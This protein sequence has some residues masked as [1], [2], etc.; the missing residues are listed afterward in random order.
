MNEWRYLFMKQEKYD[1]IKNLICVIVM[2]LSVGAYLAV[3]VILNLWHPYWYIVVAGGLICGMVS[4]ILDTMS[5]LATLK[6]E[7]NKTENLT[8]KN[9]TTTEDTNNSNDENTNVEENKN[10]NT[11]N[12]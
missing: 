8:A 9:A 5:N 6:D 3:G 7:N 12:K 11:T 4:I 2:I 10:N 1:I